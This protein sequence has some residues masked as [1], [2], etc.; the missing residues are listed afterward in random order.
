MDARYADEVTDAALD[1]DLQALLDTAPSPGFVA[2]VRT[3]IADQ[4]ARQRSWFGVWMLGGSA[5]AIAA[6]AIVAV[7]VGRVGTAHR[8][9]ATL[10]ARRLPDLRVP[11]VAS[12]LNRQF[13]I[14][15]VP[16][17]SQPERVNPRRAGIPA[18]PVEPEILVDPRE[19]AAI[20]AVIFGTRDGRIDLAA[21]A[22]ASTPSV[23]ELPPVTDIEIPA[24]TIDPIAPGTGEEGVRQ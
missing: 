18:K 16:P 22:S 21:V 1:R 2:R 8:P 15:G 11:L 3:R 5:A 9:S 12:G 23:M 17:E 14:A 10:D 13:D 19:A 7:N 24:I 6:I 20:R 4:P